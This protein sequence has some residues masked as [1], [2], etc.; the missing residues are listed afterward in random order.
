MSLFFFFSLIFATVDSTNVKLVGRA[1][2][3]D[4]L[5]L[6]FYRLSR[7]S[8]WLGLIALLT[9]IYFSR[10]PSIGRS[11]YDAHFLSTPR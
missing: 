4:I 8:I 2:F 5:F 11:Y 1:E 6:A 10:H 3:T 7:S 9:A